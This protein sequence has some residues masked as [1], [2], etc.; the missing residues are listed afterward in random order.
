MKHPGTIP[1]LFLEVVV[2][3]IH[4][5]CVVPDGDAAGQPFVTTL[6]HRVWLAN[7]YRIKKDAKE[8]DKR[9]AFYYRTGVWIA[10]QKVGKSP[11]MASE[12]LAEF[13]GP[14]R[15]AGFAQGGEVYRCEDHDCKC[16]WEYTYKPGE[17]MGKP[18]KTPRIQLA[19]VAEDQVENT[20]GALQSMV[21]FGPLGKLG[22]LKPNEDFIRHPNGLRDAVIEVVTSKAA[23][24]LGARITAGKADEIGL[25]T[26]HNGMKKFWRT[27]QRGA[28]GM[29]GRLSATTNAYDPAEE[30]QAQS[31]REK[32]GKDVLVH[33]FPPPA[34]LDFKRKADRRK[35][36][37]HNYGHSPW[38]NLDD[39][40][41]DAADLIKQGY[42]ADAER[43]F[44][45]R[46]VAG[47]KSWL[48]EQV[49]EV[50]KALELV[51]Q[52]RTLV[53]AGFDGSMNDDWT[54]IRLETLDHFQ[55]TPTYF[56]GRRPTIWDPTE[57]NDQIPRREVHEAW[58]DLHNQ[59]RIVRAYCDPFWWGTEV[60]EWQAEYGEKVFIPWPTNQPGRMWNALERFKTDVIEKD[61]GFSHDDCPTARTHVRNAVELSRG[62][63]KATGRMRYILGKASESQK[64][65]M[66]MSSVLA[67]EAA[68]DAVASGA[69]DAADPQESTVWL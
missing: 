69:R 45:N 13:L 37:Q 44:G 57:W 64:I 11:A 29:G 42:Q 39:I 28:S 26:D 34:E 62:L 3:W 47:S 16:G 31:L 25:W 51:V 66:A 43:F 6:D 58:K 12:A 9:Q 38:V 49:W 50:R 35:I 46:I 32:A 65:D 27:M 54:G 68:A 20:W 60:D 2:H 67:H 33:Y 30:S 15:F 7:W 22:V 18:W 17:P 8:E 19:A 52:P 5:H 56:N 10:A 61:T 21:R 41:S 14:V 4:R 24:R 55:F 23:T 53:A 36:F 48:S 63:D 1:A 40:E 59:F